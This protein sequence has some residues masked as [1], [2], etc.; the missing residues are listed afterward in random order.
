[1]LATRQFAHR[2]QRPRHR[3]ESVFDE[4]DGEDYFSGVMYPGL[5]I[6]S[7]FCTTRSKRL[8]S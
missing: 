8:V 7:G 2:L 3:R 5:P 6:C 1:M 4:G